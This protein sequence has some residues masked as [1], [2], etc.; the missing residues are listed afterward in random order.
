MKK[1]DITLEQAEEIEKTKF[2]CFLDAKQIVRFQICLN[3]WCLEPGLFYAALEKILGRKISS[4]FGNDVLPEYSYI[5]DDII[6]EYLQKE[7]IPTINELIE[8]LPKDKK[9][10]QNEREVQ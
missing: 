5:H 2:Y 6:D 7:T 8:M 9:Y 3:M 10:L 1:I 4:E